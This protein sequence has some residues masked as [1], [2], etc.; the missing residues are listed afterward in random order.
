MQSIHA[1]NQLPGAD[2]QLNIIYANKIMNLTSPKIEISFGVFAHVGFD[3]I[4]KILVNGADLTNSVSYLSMGNIAVT[5]TKID[6]Y[7]EIEIYYSKNYTIYIDT[8][9]I[10]VKIMNGGTLFKEVVYPIKLKKEEL[11]LQ[12][13][14]IDNNN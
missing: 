4:K 13:S 11:Q 10:K 9:A 3:S 14:Y 1:Q 2:D 5:P 7:L 12:H 6:K 8:T